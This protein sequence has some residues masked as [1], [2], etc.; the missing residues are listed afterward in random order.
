MPVHVLDPMNVY[1][2]VHNLVIFVDMVAVIQ[3]LY[4]R[5]GP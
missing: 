4:Y 3:M 5:L 1:A 2:H